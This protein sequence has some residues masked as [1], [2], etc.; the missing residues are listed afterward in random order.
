MMLP[1]SKKKLVDGLMLS[2][3]VAVTLPR[4]NYIEHLRSPLETPLTNLLSSKN[5]L[6][7]F[8]VKR[9][10][11]VEKEVESFQYIWKITDDNKQR[12]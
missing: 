5:S 12:F 7:Y 10:D 11:S 6:T 1:Y 8:K 4:K 2:L 9:V 3:S